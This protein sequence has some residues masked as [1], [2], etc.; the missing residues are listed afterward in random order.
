M[1]V[2]S[3]GQQGPSKSP[4]CWASSAAVAQA[5]RKSLKVRWIEGPTRDAAGIGTV[6]RNPGRAP[7]PRT[8]S[9]PVRHGFQYVQTRLQYRL[10]SFSNPVKTRFPYGSDTVSNTVQAGQYVQAGVQYG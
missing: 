4:P 10:G 8:V 7:R 6:S 2:A 9:I 3:S 1:A 5:D